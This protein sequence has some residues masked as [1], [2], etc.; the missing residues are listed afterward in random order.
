ME[1]KKI[2]TYPKDRFTFQLTPAVNSTD[3]SIFLDGE[4]Q[5]TLNINSSI[6]IYH[7]ENQGLL[8]FS[9]LENNKSY[10]NTLYRTFKNLL[11]DLLCKFSIKVT[12]KGSNMRLLSV[13]DE[14]LH[15]ELAYSHPIKF[16][17]IPG[18]VIEKLNSDGTN[19]KITGTE[20][21]SLLNFV[22]K[23]KQLRPPNSFTGAG[24]H[25]EGETFKIKER[26]KDD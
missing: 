8:V 12:F 5:K 1:L 7:N 26:K 20:R 18:L 23:L 14:F 15:L 13:D 21:I 11:E 2:L 16:K 4:N 10:L 22:T 24:I 3:I 6:L 17:L 25:L 9:S 19:I